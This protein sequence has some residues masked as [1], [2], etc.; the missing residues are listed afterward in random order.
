MKFDI[1]SSKI[2]VTEPI[3]MYIEEK[4][5]KLNKYL[6]KPDDI[7]VRVR[8]RLSGIHQ[9]VEVTIPLNKVILRAEE[10]QDDLYAAID[11]VSEKLERQIRKNKSRMKKKVNKEIYSS[12]TDFVEIEKDESKIVRRKY[13]ETKPMDEEEAILQMNL[14][15]HDFYVF[16]DIKSTKTVLLYKRKDNDYGIIEFN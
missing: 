6:D 5:G 2:K 7:N 15:G 8:I 12:F 9:V 14:L 11:L 10:R 4:L 16:E 13:I 3:K 1:H